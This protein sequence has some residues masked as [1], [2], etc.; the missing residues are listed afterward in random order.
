MMRP[1]FRSI[2]AVTVFASWLLCHAALGQDQTPDLMNITGNQFA[3][4]AERDTTFR[5]LGLMK[6]V[7]RM[8]EY[9]ESSMICY[10]PGSTYEQSAKIINYFMWNHPEFLHFPMHEIAWMALARAFPCQRK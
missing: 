6:I 1:F 3:V 10:P 5:D 2:A 9:K 8:G 7:S 4:L